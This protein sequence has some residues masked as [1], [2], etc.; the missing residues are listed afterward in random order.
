MNTPPTMPR[1][2][3]RSQVHGFTVRGRLV[4]GAASLS[5]L[6]DSGSEL[7]ELEGHGGE[8]LEA[9]CDE[10]QLAFGIAASWLS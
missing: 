8:L 3:L 6:D 1:S 5:E 4:A 7:D 9:G 10:G 2:H